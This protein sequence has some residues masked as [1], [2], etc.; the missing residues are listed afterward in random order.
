MPV[1]LVMYTCLKRKRFIIIEREMCLGSARNHTSESILWRNKL[2]GV[3]C[4]AV[5]TFT[6]RTKHLKKDSYIFTICVFVSRR[7]CTHDDNATVVLLI[8]I[9]NDVFSKAYSRI[10][11]VVTARCNPAYCNRSKPGNITDHNLTETIVLRQAIWTTYAAG[12][13]L[14][15]EYFRL[16]SKNRKCVNAFYFF[17]IVNRIQK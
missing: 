3:G 17:C 11:H 10:P 16:V 2:L 15:Q 1:V 12:I 8:P 6:P 7:R 14:Y 9:I 4:C 13:F 5:L